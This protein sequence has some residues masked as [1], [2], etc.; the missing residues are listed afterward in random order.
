VAKRA[1]EVWRFGIS[2]SEAFFIRNA[3]YH[4]AIGFLRNAAAWRQN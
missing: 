2:V 4:T 3:L 1:A